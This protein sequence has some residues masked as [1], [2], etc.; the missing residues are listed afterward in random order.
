MKTLQK[1]LL[2]LAAASFL[3]VGAQAAV[4]MGEGQPYV[5]AKVG[6]FL[7]DVD[8]LDNPTA[9]GAVAGYKFT[10]AV[11]AEVEYVGSSSK[12]VGD[13]DYNLKTY[14]IYGTYTYAFP[15]TAVYAKGHLGLAKAELEVESNALNFNDTSSDSG[16]AGGVAVGYNF[17]PNMAIE[18]EWAYVAEDVSLLTLGATYKF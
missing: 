4:S 8:D 14:G 16:I 12:S 17:N 10:P 18:G 5:G 15:D 1:S 11:G 2:V 13:L 9:F 3:S 6:K 7:L